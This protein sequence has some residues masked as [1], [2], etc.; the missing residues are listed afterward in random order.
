MLGRDKHLHTPFKFNPHWLE[1]EDLISLLKNTWKVYDENSA[2][3][4]ASQFNATLKMIKNEAICWF[5]KRKEHD[6]K[7][8]VEIEGLLLDACTKLGFGYA[9]NEGKAS[10]YALESRRR[11][12]LLDR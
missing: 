4:P 6:T 1:H 7:D 11:K 3:S 10:L 8:L 9:N 12:I 2:L 5:V